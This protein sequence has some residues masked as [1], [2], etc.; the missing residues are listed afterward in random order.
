MSFQKLSDKGLVKIYKEFPLYSGKNIWF[1]FGCTLRNWWFFLEGLNFFFI[2]EKVSSIGK[3]W[4]RGC[5]KCAKCDKTLASGSHAEVFYE[6]QTWLRS[7]HT[8]SVISFTT[9]F[10]KRLFKTKNI[11]PSVFLRILSVKITEK[12]WTSIFSHFLFCKLVGKHL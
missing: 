11:Y 12:N 4:H 1:T 10:L 2:A 9:S 3:D 5:L 7:E 8:Q 6:Y